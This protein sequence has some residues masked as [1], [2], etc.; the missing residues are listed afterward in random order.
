[1]DINIICIDNKNKPAEYTS[2]DKWLVEGQAY[3]PIKVAYLIDGNIGV[4]VEEITLSED[5][6]FQY[7]NINRFGIPEENIEE[8]EAWIKDSLENQKGS[9]PE[10]DIEKLTEKTLVEDGTL[11]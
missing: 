10:I 2:T 1:M 6:P 3:S 8:F 7:F 11:V 4:K 5:N 9:G